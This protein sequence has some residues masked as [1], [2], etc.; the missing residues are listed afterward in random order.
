MHRGGTGG[1]VGIFFVVW[2]YGL[3][4]NGCQLT[5]YG[6]GSWFMVHGSW[7]MIDG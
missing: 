5:D 3:L 1:G 7:F 2:A 4:V 6:Y